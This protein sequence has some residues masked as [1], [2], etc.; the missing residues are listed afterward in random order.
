LHQEKSMGIT[1]KTIG[2]GQLDERVAAIK[3]QQRE[4]DARALKAGRITREA[5]ARKNSLFSGRRLQVDL[6]SGGRLR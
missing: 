1:P 5:L 3:Q 4:A 6:K 2:R